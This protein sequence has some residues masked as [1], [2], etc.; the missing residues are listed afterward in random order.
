M[1]I[2]NGCYYYTMLVLFINNFMTT[3][4]LSLGRVLHVLL[5]ILHGSTFAS[6][7]DFSLDWLECLILRLA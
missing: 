1:V 5:K 7:N 2:I 3:V 6:I 4:K